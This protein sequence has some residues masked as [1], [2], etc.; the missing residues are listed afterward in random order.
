M[1]LKLSSEAAVIIPSLPACKQQE[2]GERLPVAV[3]ASVQ[4]Q[5]T[6][7]GNAAPARGSSAGLLQDADRRGQ[8][9]SA[10][11]ACSLL[12]LRLLSLSPSHPFSPEPSGT[13]RPGGLPPRR[14]H[15][16][17]PQQGWQTVLQPGLGC[18]PEPQTAHDRPSSPHPTC[19]RGA[20]GAAPGQEGSW[21]RVSKRVLWASLVTKSLCTY[22]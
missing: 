8:N 4:P 16:H 7:L 11:S 2:A 14:G 22:C 18:S 5:H 21:M 1:A 12:L 17:G 15:C 19:L 3:T 13:L 9:P 6:R 10:V 20:F